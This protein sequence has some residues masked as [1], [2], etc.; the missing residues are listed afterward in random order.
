MRRFIGTIYFVLIILDLGAQGLS[1]QLSLQETV[2]LATSQSASSIQARNL[3]ENKY[4]QWK[5]HLSNY[6]PQLELGGTLPDFTRSFVP[7]SQPDGNI[8]FQP[9]NYNNSS[10]GLSLSQSLA[11][12]GGQIY[13]NSSM[14]RFDDFENDFTQFSGTPV[15]FGFSQPLFA[16]NRLAWDRK[17]EP[18]LYEQSKKFYPADLERISLE[19]TQLYFDLQLAQT[20]LEVAYNNLSNTDTLLRISQSRYDLGRISESTLLQ[21]QLSEINSRKALSSAQVAKEISLLKLKSYL[22]LQDTLPLILVLPDNMPNF[23]VDAAIALSTALQN[24][25]KGLGFQISLMESDRAL[26]EA[27]GNNGLSATLFAQIGIANAAR[28]AEGIYRNTQESQNLR[29]GFTVPILDWGRAAAKIKSAKADQLMTQNIVDQEAINFQ[30]EVYALVTRFHM[31]REQIKDAKEAD[32]I[33]ERRYQISKQRYIIGNYELTEL[34]IAQ[35]EKDQAKIDY[36]LSLRSYWLAYYEL[37][38]V[39]L[40]DFERGESLLV[41]NQN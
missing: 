29:I 22:N 15:A 28:N 11:I 38:M 1:R 13:L 39:T 31:L 34:N 12:T 37:R 25:P 32:R 18:L 23:E 36:L 4:W 17:I 24:S 41:Q 27:K 2:H 35:S 9:V 20:Q 8:V 3:R 16:Y 30:Q 6:K 26:A 21:L 33:A 40:Y 5:A 14:Q 19:A 7:V 10:L